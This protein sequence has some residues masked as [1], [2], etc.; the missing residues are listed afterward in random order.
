MSAFDCN[1]DPTMTYTCVPQKFNDS[2]G[3]CVLM[4]PAPVTSPPLLN[5]IVAG[6]ELKPTLYGWQ[7]LVIIFII[8]LACVGAAIILFKA[9][10]ATPEPAIVLSEMNI[11]SAS[12]DTIAASLAAGGTIAAGGGTVAETTQLAVPRSFLPVFS[13][14]GGSV[15]A[16]PAAE[17]SVG[18]YG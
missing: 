5:A 2:L 11:G 1:K 8:I 16:K 18:T 17:T 4:P 15:A 10:S 13:G 9:A 7:L 3:A 12:V 14:G 6:S